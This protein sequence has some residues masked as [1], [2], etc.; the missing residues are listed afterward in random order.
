M[1]F[2]VPPLLAGD[3][4]SGEDGLEHNVSDD[5]FHDIDAGARAD[6]ATW[7]TCSARAT[8]ARSRYAL[9]KQMAVRLAPPRR[10]RRATSTATT[11]DRDAAR[12][13]TARREQADAIY[14]LTALCTFEDRFVIP[15]MHREEA[16]E[17]MEEPQEWKQEAGFGFRAAPKR[18]A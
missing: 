3:V 14:R 5:L 15:P 8:R 17:M 1:L 10:D 11:A 9:R 2:Y 6:G 16:I 18:G 12:G 13:R 4:A 7:R